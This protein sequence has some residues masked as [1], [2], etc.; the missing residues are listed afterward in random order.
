MERNPLA[1]EV[2]G[3]IY[4]R[5][6]QVIPTSTSKSDINCGRKVE[7]A[8]TRD[9]IDECVVIL[10]VIFCDFLIKIKIFVVCR[11]LRHLCFT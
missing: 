9:R 5:R 2:S 7:I 1:E 6:G 4:Q 3:A 10:G 8:F 11:H